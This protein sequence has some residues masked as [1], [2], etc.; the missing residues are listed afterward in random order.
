MKESFIGKHH[1]TT[2]FH[3]LQCYRKKVLKNGIDTECKEMLQNLAEEYKFQILAMEVMPDHI[4]LLVDC[5]P[6]FY[7]SDMIK[8][9][10]GNLARQM[11][12]AYPELKKELWGGHLW[13]PSYCAITVSDRSRD[14]V[15]AYIE[16]QKEKEKS[17]TEEMICWRKRD[18]DRIQLWRRITKTEYPGPP[19]TGNLPVCG[20]LPDRNI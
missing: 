14:Q 16:G 3:T 18:A 8:I 6:Q 12:L 2:F 19:D 17:L 9:M 7:I 13:N 15:L 10:K 11:F 4:L 1:F 20:Q 5:K